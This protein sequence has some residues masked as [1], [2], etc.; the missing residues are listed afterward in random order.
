MGL[1]ARV[2]STLDTNKFIPEIFS[3]QIAE[4]THAK[5][6]CWNLTDN[7]WAKELVKGDT[8]YIPKTNIIVASEV[9]VGS[10]STARNA[11]ATT[12]VTGS[13]NYWYDVNYPVD[14]MS[15]RQTQVDHFAIAKHEIAYAL[16]KKMDTS[17]NTLFSAF[18]SATVLGTDGAAI[19]DKVLLSAWETLAKADVPMDDGNLFLVVNPSGIV[20]FMDEDK[21]VNKL[22]SDNTP[23]TN[24]F[25]G[26]HKVYGCAVYCTNN[27]TNAT[28]GA[29][30]AMFHRK[31]IATI[32]QEEVDMDLDHVARE[33][34]TYINGAALWGVIEVRNDFGVAIYTRS[35]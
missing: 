22:Y 32:A 30:A 11:A 12:G 17:V 27:L 15:A 13:I 26:F 29:Y 7:S 19:T 8:W 23:V 9:V 25:R 2:P 31:A 24:G 20:D 4:A 18:N 35:R 1:S 33:H 5:L 21:L 34:Q 16:A 6:V 28:T 3:K 10:P 14:D